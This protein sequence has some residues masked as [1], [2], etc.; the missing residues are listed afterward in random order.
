MMSKGP[1]SIHT[2]QCTVI[3][4][5][6][7]LIYF[8]L[9]CFFSKQFPK[10]HFIAYCCKDFGPLICPCKK[11]PV[12]KKLVFLRTC[13][14]LIMTCVVKTCIRHRLN[15]KLS[16]QSYYLFRQAVNV[17]FIV[18]SITN[19]DTNSLSYMTTLT[20]VTKVT[21]STCY[22]LA[23][24]HSLYVYPSD[25]GSTIQP[26]TKWQDCEHKYAIVIQLYVFLTTLVKHKY[27][28]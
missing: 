16:Q 8:E 22:C 19:I 9:T 24:K 27:K 23:S 15:G 18:N 2:I 4:T 13:V 25:Q 11:Y 10:F 12:V 1:I 14:C 21:K 26:Y 20:C 6:V 28:T 7:I 17:S 3:K 5:Q